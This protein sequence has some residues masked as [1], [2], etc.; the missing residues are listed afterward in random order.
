MPK[1]GK[2]RKTRNVKLAVRYRATGSEQEI[3]Y[4]ARGI[5]GYKEGIYMDDKE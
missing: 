2:V 3:E 4:E 1:V 5:K